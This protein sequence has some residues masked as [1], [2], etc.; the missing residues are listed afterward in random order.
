VTPALK[1]RQVHRAHREFKE[2]RVLRDRLERTVLK[3][4]R[5]LPGKR[6]RRGTREIKEKKAIPEKGTRRTR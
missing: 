3:G 6:A 1:D 5:A 4:R 2:W